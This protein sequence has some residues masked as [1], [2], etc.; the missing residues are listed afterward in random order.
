MKHKAKEFTISALCARAPFP[1]ASEQKK[2]KTTK[3][4]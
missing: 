2:K 1:R 3:I 4:T